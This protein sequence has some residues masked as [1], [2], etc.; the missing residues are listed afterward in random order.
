MPVTRTAAQI[1]TAAETVSAVL[2]AQNGAD[3]GCLRDAASVFAKVADQLA[4]E[5]R[6]APTKTASG[7]NEAALW[8]AASIADGL[9]WVAAGTQDTTNTALAAAKGS[10]PAA[11]DVF[12]RVGSAVQFVCTSAVRVNGH[13]YDASF[14]E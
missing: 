3:A 10:A 4:T 14:Y 9:V 2:K 11:G 6:G 7:S 5:I 1:T 12:Q 13:G 8:T